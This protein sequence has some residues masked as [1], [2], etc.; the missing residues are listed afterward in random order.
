MIKERI[1]V[2]AGS[3]DPVTIGHKAIVIKAL[4][5]FDRV[6]VL[7]GENSSK[8]TLFSLE[9]RK[10]WLEQTFE[11]Q[12]NVSV[13]SYKGLTVDFCKQNN[14]NF[15]VRGVRNEADFQYEKN[16]AAI[17]KEIAPDIETIFLLTDKD[18]EVVSSSFVREM[19][20]HKKDVSRYLPKGV[21]IEN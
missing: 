16:I 17:N 13:C 1:A 21:E 3:F 4:S 2:F 11:I 7:L 20:L 19:I 15:I 9:Q 18:F 12:D 14:V 10:K 6:I 5:L 8:K